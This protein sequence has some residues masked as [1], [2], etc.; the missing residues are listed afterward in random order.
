MSLKLNEY[1]CKK[2]AR[3]WLEAR[4]GPKCTFQAR[5]TRAASC[6]QQAFSV[7]PPNAT[8]NAAIL[9]GMVHQP[10][11]TKINHVSFW[12]KLQQ[13][14]NKRRCLP[15]ITIIV[16]LL[17]HLYLQQQLRATCPPP[18]NAPRYSLPPAVCMQD[19]CAPSSAAT[20]SVMVSLSKNVKR[21]HCTCLIVGG[22]GKL[23]VSS[24]QPDSKP[25]GR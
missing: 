3:A 11:G 6:L 16:A 7:S 8:K 17:P 4:P 24:M 18:P 9:G 20:S 23:G 1:I 14:C 12:K 10:L 25:R 15:T 5:S 19:T 13:V 2:E 21:R 22:T